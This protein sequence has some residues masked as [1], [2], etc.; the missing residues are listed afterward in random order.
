MLKHAFKEWAVICEALAL[1]R[2]ALILRKGGIAENS[3]SFRLEHTQFWLFPTYIHQ[4]AAGIV[5]DAFPLLESAKADR[6]KEGLMRLDHFAV[7]TGFY[8][9]HDMVG[10]LRLAP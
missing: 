7:V 3:G 6:P 9:I 1:G 4:Q 10:A 2:Q 8:L 5:P